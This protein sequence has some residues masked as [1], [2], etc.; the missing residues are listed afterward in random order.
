MVSQPQQL[1]FIGALVAALGL[2]HW[3]RRL[4]WVF[5]LLVLPGTLVHETC[6]FLLGLFLNGQPASFNL[7]PRR[8]VKGRG[9]VMGSVA[10]ANL[11]WYNA[12]FVGMAPL[13]MLPAAWLLL[14][15]RLQA[16]P[17]WTWQ[18]ALTVYLIANLIYAAM[19][20]WQD[21]KIAAR[22]PIGWLLLAGT[23]TW[24]YL[25]YSRTLHGHGPL[26]NRAQGPAS[27]NFGPC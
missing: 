8:D 1:L 13:L 14:R 12:F 27:A 21:C 7:I 17:V 26:Q 19:P 24:G 22:S 10:C 2:F 3:A 6:H 25:H 15:W 23:L 11:R 20:S 18:E 9:W 4:F 5:S 16:G